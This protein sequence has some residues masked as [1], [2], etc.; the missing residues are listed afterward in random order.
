M[1]DNKTDAT[2]GVFPLVRIAALRAKQ[3]QAGARP[4]VETN[5]HT[6]LRVALMEVTAGMVSWNIG[7][8][9]PTAAAPAKA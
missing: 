6:T 9:P 5:G 4:R 8:A 7:E 1:T 2:I 3:L